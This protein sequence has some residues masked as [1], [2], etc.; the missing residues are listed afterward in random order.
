MRFFVS[1]R[2]HFIFVSRSL[3]GPLLR[4][5]PDLA[6]MKR[7]KQLEFQAALQANK[8]R[9]KQVAEAK[10]LRAEA[11]KGAKAEDIGPKVNTPRN[12]YGLIAFPPSP[13]G[14]Y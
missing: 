8:E 14:C 5:V 13:I 10:R 6:E 11:L 1:F 2:F 3:P 9:A 12:M 7:R 4:Q